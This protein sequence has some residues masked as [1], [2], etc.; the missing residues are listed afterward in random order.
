MS[1]IRSTLLWA[2]L[3]ALAGAGSTDVRTQAPDPT[4]GIVAFLRQLETIMRAA[5]GAAFLNLTAAT[6]DPRRAHDFAELEL[7]PGATR[8]AIQERDRTALAGT[9][10]GN[11]Y[12]LI[13]DAFVEYGQRARA[14]TWRLDIKRDGDAWRL[15]D[16][17]RITSVENLYRLSLNPSK[18]YDAHDLT[19]KAEDL[20]LVLSDGSLF[21]A[22]TD[23]GVT[24]IVLLGHGEMHFHPAPDTEKG[25]VK[26][27]CGAE[28]LDTRFDSAFI[29]INPA[30]FDSLIDEHHATPR[31]S[32]D[33]RDFK[34]ADEVFRDEMPKSFGLDLGDLS[35]D[36]WS[37]LPTFGDFLAEIRTKRFDTLTY[38][39]S[40]TEA[41][42]ITLFDRRH[43]KNIALYPSVEKLA[44][45]GR[46]YNEDDLAD[47][48][49]LDYS[50]DVAYSPERL[51]LDGRA[52]LR[53]K[54]RAAALSTITFK[55]ADP[56]VVQSV[57][58]DQ[59]GRLFS[60]RV[61]NQNS[62]VVNLPVAVARDTQLTFTLVYAGRIE[63]QA[64]DRET[65][66]VV[67]R[68]PLAEDVQL[69]PPEPSYLYS[70]RSLWYP[71]AVVTDYATARIRMTIPANFDCV[72]SGDLA[73]GYPT[74]DATRPDLGA[75]KV[76]LFTAQQPIRYLAFLVSRFTKPETTVA[77]IVPSEARSGDGDGDG[78]GPLPSLQGVSYE[79]LAL[80]V[81]T[82]PR[83]AGRSHELLERAVD[84]AKYYASILGDCPYP[85]FT[86]ALIENPLPGGHSPGYF[87]ALNH[88]A[89]LSSLTWRNDPAAFNNYPEFFIA[90]EIAHQWWG[91]A[92]GWRSYH[93]QW[94]SEGFAQYF[95]ALYAQH[96]RGDDIF[97]GVMRQMRHFAIADDDQGPVYLGYRLGH[98]KG[99]SR[100][101]R[102]LVYNK[103]AVV[104]HML[105]RLV[106]DEAFFHGLR[107]FYRESRFKKAGT[108]DLRAAMERESGMHLERFFERWIYSTGIPKL[109]F[110]YRVE[111]GGQEAVFHVEQVGEIFDVP[112]TVTLQYND[113]K[114]VDVVIPVTDRAVD[115]RV[116]L[117]G[118]LRGVDLRTDDGM[119]AEIVK[120][121]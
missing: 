109:K 42:D 87:V 112:V 114:P 25:Q 88:A 39:R 44:R 55:L 50:L 30:D 13:V 5:D 54:V 82:N 56:L 113:K 49:I 3:F 18:Q 27:F 120:S 73:T 78:N 72:A 80:S 68:S 15:A 89:P 94:L 86:V 35:R 90:H 71:Q 24:G 7:V 9:L 97:D 29:R 70:N 111:P 60:I 37:L 1:R 64:A 108:E 101:F 106:G 115:K 57:V 58:S 121:S 81:E 21:V 105:R 85:S 96:H 28:T 8:V 95:A 46:F 45:R 67:Q 43:R 98:I 102:A 77:T 23:Q 48:D 59:L 34:R 4:D 116:K 22:D 100:V 83:E 2:M 41:E 62:V 17:E 11:G 32:V 76:Y 14:S 93:E 92:V 84:V 38:A 10:P 107:R 119:L 26:I 16:Q 99:D 31:A 19:L 118:T 47:Y 110:G 69:I 20:E 104:L 91:Q 66:Q 33:A 63:P 74:V 75:R 36:S 117:E 51:W 6:A 12:R 79:G 53:I 103:G 52:R 61:R 40:A 65:I